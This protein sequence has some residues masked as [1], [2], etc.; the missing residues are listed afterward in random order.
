MYLH[1]CFHYDNLLFLTV[2]GYLG[3]YANIPTTWASSSTIM[4]ITI[5][6]CLS[7]CRWKGNQIAALYDGTKCE[8]G[9]DMTNSGTMISVSE[10]NAPCVGDSSQFCGGYQR[11]SYYNGKKAIDRCEKDL[12]HF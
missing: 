8:C 5:D 1:H 11:T 6:K 3:C 12:Q 7:S 9:D 2:P 4:D 10:C